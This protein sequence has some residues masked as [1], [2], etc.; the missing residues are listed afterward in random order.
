MN[1]R[2]DQILGD[3]ALFVEVAKTKSIKRTA[4]AL[5]IP[6]STL[7]RRL[8]EL[9]RSLG[10]QLLHRTTRRIDLTEAG[11]LYYAKC[12]KVVEAAELANAQLKD[13]AESPRGVLRLSLPAD[14]SALFIA[15]LVAEFIR[16]YPLV[17]FDFRLTEQWVDLVEHGIDIAIR[18]GPQADSAL[19]IRH[20]G[21]I[22]YALYASPEYI[23]TAGAPRHPSELAQHACIRMT[24]PALA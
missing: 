1:A 18:L 19:T 10:V 22:H 5:G 6:D 9:E 24:C 8:T 4:E 13:D 23:R 2:I 11:Q 15:P 20:L 17:H 21:E 3:V 14:F 12:R 7:S 16:I